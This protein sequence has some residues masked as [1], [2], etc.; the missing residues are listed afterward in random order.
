M[1]EEELYLEL[2]NFSFV[3]NTSST[4]QMPWAS[5]SSPGSF[6]PSSNIAQ[7]MH[8][9]NK[10]TSNSANPVPATLSN[11]PT[12]ITKSM[13]KYKKSSNLDDNPISKP[14]TI[15]TERSDD[16]IT[17]NDHFPNL[18]NKI[19]QTPKRKTRSSISKSPTIETEKSDDAVIV[20][21]DHLPNLPPTPTSL[22]RKTRSSYK[23]SN[24]AQKLADI[25]TNIIAVADS[26][27]ED[28]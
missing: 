22:K 27:P 10:K 25:A 17:Q 20:Q 6:T 12:N 18:H 3:R 15:E 23:T 1:I 21:D 8:K 24:K 14:P 7:S 5:K 13:H 9:L 2:Q 4:K 19:P 26:D 16:T 11:T 28:E